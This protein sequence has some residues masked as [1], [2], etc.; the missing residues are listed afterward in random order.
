[1]ARLHT[2]RKGEHGSKHPVRAA[3]P[4]WVQQDSSELKELVVRLAKE[5]YSTA[6]I[7]T[8]LRDQYGVPSVKLVT[9]EKLLEILKEHNIAPTLPEDLMNVIKQALRTRRHIEVHKKDISNKR[10]LTLVE[11]K[12]HRLVK[13]YKKKGILPADWTYEPEKAALLIK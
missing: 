1:M 11:S 13:Y 10:N 8:I 5:G 3:P 6:M 2:R 9:G 4:S 7:G 12:I